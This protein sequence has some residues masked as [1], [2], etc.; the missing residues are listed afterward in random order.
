ML[1]VMKFNSFLLCMSALC[2]A[3]CMNAVAD[4]GYYD[5]K[6]KCMSYYGLSLTMPESV[7]ATFDKG[8]GDRIFFFGKELPE[9]PTL[10]IFQGGPVI[11]LDKNCHVVLKD[12]S[13][14][15]KP[16]PESFP[17]I[18]A[19]TK[20]TY[21]TPFS[22]MMLNNCDLPWA[23]WYLTGTGGVLVNGNKGSKP[24]EEIL[25][26]VEECRSKYISAL[27]GTSL[28]DHTNTDR[29]FVVKIPNIDK[30]QCTDAKLNNMLKSDN[31]ECYGVEFYSA[32]RYAFVGMLLFINTKSGKTIND[33]VDQMSHYISFDKDFVL[34]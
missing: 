7:V 2:F 11:D 10:P 21:M 29:I 31:M 26:K 23:N 1:G 25:Q 17:D 14:A 30:I 13:N 16:N 5:Y 15:K 24:S 33:Y 20:D 27:S 12:L 8:T 4:D 19:Q 28:T 34:K 3:S 22:G 9:L 6:A 32:D 18:D